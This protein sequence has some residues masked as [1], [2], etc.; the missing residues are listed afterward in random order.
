MYPPQLLLSSDCLAN[1]ATVT[2]VLRLEYCADNWCQ[3]KSWESLFKDPS[4]Y[5]RCTSDIVTDW[6]TVVEEADET[7]KRQCEGEVNC[8][9]D[10]IVTEDVDVGLRTLEEAKEN[11]FTP[12]PEWTEK[13]DEEENDSYTCAKAG[14]GSETA[15]AR[16]ADGSG[17]FLQD[18]LDRWGWRITIPG[19]SSGSYQYDVYAGAG[20]C[21][22]APAGGGVAVGTLTVSYDATT[23]Q[24]EGTY[25][26]T[27]GHTLQEFQFYCG[28]EPY[29]KTA[30]GA[31]TVAPGKYSCK[32]LETTDHLS[33]TCVVS[34][35]EPKDGFVSVIAHAVSCNKPDGST[36][37]GRSFNTNQKIGSGSGDPHFKVRSQPVNSVTLWLCNDNF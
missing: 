34:N 20:Q 35:I 32:H 30:N 27:G 3:E 36:P 13:D 10:A 18:G 29:P 19:S 17:C 8:I 21:Q 15:F 28:G 25:E 2:L 16:P 7:I 11:G 37:Q 9:I 14:V 1:I 4:K 24:C 6:D 5:H 22:L 12:D 26:A 33:D 23:Q 31:N